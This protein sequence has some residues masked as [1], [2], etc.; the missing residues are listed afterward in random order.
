M[1]TTIS[2]RRH[3]PDDTVL[4]ALRRS[5]IPLTCVQAARLTRLTYHGTQLALTRL[6]NAGHVTTATT[7]GV[8]E[9]RPTPPEPHRH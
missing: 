4:R 6:I 9:Y 8:T 7:D 5:K 1:N 3:T 2:T